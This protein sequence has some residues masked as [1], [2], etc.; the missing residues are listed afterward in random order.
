MITVLVTHDVDEA[1]ALADRIFV[2]SARPTHV[3]SEI[4]IMRPRAAMGDEE[5]KAIAARIEALREPC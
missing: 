5:R 4:Q 1:I 3:V 2:L